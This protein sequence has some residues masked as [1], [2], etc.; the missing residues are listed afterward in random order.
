MDDC[1]R[2]DEDIDAEI[3]MLRQ[4]EV[5]C[6]TVL[7]DASIELA[8]IGAQVTD[9]QAGLK[10]SHARIAALEQIKKDRAA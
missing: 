5:D 9:A 7:T 8:N 6:Q 1:N 10:Y 3:E 2:T 4:S